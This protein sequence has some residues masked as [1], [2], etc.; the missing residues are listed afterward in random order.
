M[1]HGPS[2]IVVKEFVIKKIVI[3]GPGLEYI[4]FVTYM[5]MRVEEILLFEFH[6]FLFTKERMILEHI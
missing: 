3:H 2:R 6:I 5:N 1:I 4:A